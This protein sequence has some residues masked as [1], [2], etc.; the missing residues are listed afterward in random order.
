MDQYDTVIIGAGPAGLF[1]ALH[2]AGRHHRV[3][4]LE[5]N[6]EPG[7][8]L[9]LSGSGQCNL[10]HAGNI[11]TFFDR[12][13]A[14]GRFLRPSL[15]AFTNES[16]SRF[17]TDRGLPVETTDGGK[18]FPVSRSAAD[19]CSLLTGECEKNGVEIAYGE[20]VER[21]TTGSRGFTL[22]TPLRTIA[23]C[24]VVIAT[25]G[26]SYP[27]TGSSGDGYRLAASLGHHITG[28]WPALTPV[29]AKDFVFAGLAGLSFYDMPFS[30]WR[31]GR[32]IFSKRG[33][34]LFTH[35][36]LSGPG[37]LDS[38][39]D[40]RPGDLLRLSFSGTTDRDELTGRF[41]GIITKNPV[42]AVK[43]LVAELGVP[44]RLAAV[45]VAQAGI[46]AECTG[47]HLTAAGRSRLMDCLTGFPVTVSRV[48]DLNVAMATSGGIALEEV[49]PK[50]MESRIVPG[51]F[52]AGEVLDID[53]DTGGFN[54]QAAFS[55]GFCA[56]QGI[57]SRR[58]GKY[59]Q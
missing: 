22:H 35:T 46:P 2:A 3:L 9:M 47:A 8:K 56:V 27:R 16:L 49:N 38:S 44:D 6:K 48:G 1:C 57:I 58:T 40:I 45:L 30:L 12:Y 13:G 7:V 31:D 20:P 33:D 23:A 10:T 32:K 24:S 37:I 5:K 14:N 39:R 36:G 53:G 42:R 4:L 59:P 11:R 54:L 25:G 51:L 17:F 34:I 15:M 18:I 43:T 55:T 52:F 19:V 41:T 21:I 28:I 26:A 50:T 29:I